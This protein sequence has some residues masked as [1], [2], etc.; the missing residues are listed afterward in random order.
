MWA[1]W[2]FW[3]F[4]INDHDLNSF[5]HLSLRFNLHF[6]IRVAYL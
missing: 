3:C 6:G 4:L 5:D 1:D 2:A